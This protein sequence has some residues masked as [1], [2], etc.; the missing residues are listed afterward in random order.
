MKDI[1]DSIKKIMK[2]LR[3]NTC[4]NYRKMHG[5]PMRRWK[6]EEKI[7]DFKS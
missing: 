4:N 3:K 6:Q 1:P 7:N 5:L 2:N